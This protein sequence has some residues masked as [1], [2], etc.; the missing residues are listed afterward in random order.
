M[1]W[2]LNIANGFTVGF[3]VLNSSRQSPSED[4]VSHGTYISLSYSDPGQ[5]PESLCFCY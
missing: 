3:F 1:P 4:S 2:N 5:A